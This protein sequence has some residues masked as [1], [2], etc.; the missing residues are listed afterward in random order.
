MDNSFV[1]LRL[2]HHAAQA[3]EGFWPSFTDIMTVILMIFMLAMVVL[4]IRNME[5]LD[6][7]RSTMAAEQEAMELVKTTGEENQTL[8]ERLL[9]REYELS[10]MRMQLMRAEE[11]QEAAIASQL[12]QISSLS[13]ERDDLESN[14]TRLTHDKDDLNILVTRLTHDK[15]NLN[16]QV[17]RLTTDTNRLQLQVDDATRSIDNLTE[18]INRISSRHTLAQ[19]ELESLRTSFRAQSEELAQAQAQNMDADQTLAD[20]KI[21]FQA[22]KIKYDKL[23]RPAR[24]SRDKFVVVV[25]FAKIKGQLVIDYKAPGSETFK[26]VSRKQLDQSL[27]RLKAQESNQLYVKVII[28]K[29]SGLSYNEAWTFTNQ[30]HKKY[31]YYFQEDAKK[32]RM[33]NE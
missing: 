29:N 15:D 6:Q 17:S 21:D 28:P 14:V 30:M 27:T 8:E 2:N 10:M 12:H 13:R 24:T 18:D 22:L 7:L 23:I 5:L 19:D 11:Q 9:S 33:I 16:V 4:L 3:E 26:T 32:E 25:R 31:D 1:D 20:L